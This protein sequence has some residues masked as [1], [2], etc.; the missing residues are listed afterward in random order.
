MALSGSFNT[1]GSYSTTDGSP[2]YTVFSWSGTQNIE[3][4][5][6]DVAWS[7]TV[8]GGKNEYYFVYV[9]NRLVQ[10]D[11]AQ[12]GKGSASKKS[13]NGTVLLSGTTRIYHNDDGTG[14]FT[15]YAGV[16][17]YYSGVYNSTKTQTFT[18]DTIPR[19]PDIPTVSSPTTTT[20]SETSTSI[21]VK[22]ATTNRGTYTVEVSKNGGAYSAVKTDIAIGTLSYVHTITPKQGDTYRYRIKAVWNSLSSDY[23]YSGTVTLNK[24]N[25]PTIGTLNTYN[26]YVNATLSVPLS[27]GSQTNGGSFM[28]MAALYHGSTKLATCTTPSNGN[29]TASISYSTTNFLSRLGTT[30]Y[31]D[32][33]KIVAWIQN[34][35]GSVSSSVEKTFTVNINSDGGATPTLAIPTLSGGMLGYPATCFVAGISK[36]TVTSGTAAT[37]RAPSGTT[38]SYTIAC[39]GA[40]TATS[41]STTFNGLTA[42]KKTITVTVKDSRGLSTSQTVYCKFQSW[43]KPTIK[44]TKAERNSTTPTTIN[45]TYEYSITNIYAYSTNADTAGTQLNAINTQQYTTA[46]SYTACTSPFS[47]TGTSEESTYT[48]TVRVSDKVATTTYSSAARTVGTSTVYLASRSHGIGLNCIPASGY[49]LDVNGKARIGSASGGNAIIDNGRITSNATTPSYLEGSKGLAL[50]NSTAP[51]GD[52]IALTKTNST[53]GYFTLA[54]YNDH[55]RLNYMAKSKIDANDNTNTHSVIL[56]KEDGTSGFA[57]ANHTHS[58]YAATNHGNHVP[59]TQTAS[60]KVFLRNDNT[61]QTIT[62]ANI[63]AAAASHTHGNIQK[64]ASARG[65]A[66]SLSLT[67]GTITQ[68]TLS[69]FVARTDTS[70]SFSDGGVKCP[71]AG[72]VMVSG[73]VYF[74][75]TSGGRGVY[76]KKGD[77]EIV[78]TYAHGVSAVGCSTSGVAIISVAAGDIIYLCARSTVAT[79]CR[80]NNNGTYL[81]I[82]Y[83]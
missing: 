77:D 72:T 3:G 39:T 4:N 35:N 74:D 18:L 81:N 55:F 16:G 49:R 41:S 59:A 64:A 6:T 70:F 22:W 2:D 42:G 51:A 33:F 82:A 13:F 60:N 75:S 25:A 62:P 83:I 71:Y 37:R 5:Y 56:L 54:S 78:S 19:H 32:T 50:V 80:P 30:K 76:I 9:Y 1:S 48:I 58:N 43:A 7:L 38:L 17:F 66:A 79:T 20:V 44:I 8:A 11:G 46:S 10:I 12:V 28:R 23:S 24:L 34:S 53:N 45:V 40:T 65:T 67:A 14:S 29:T 21:T 31:S 69:S 73:N 27:G 36:L 26:P 57:F 68:L 15:A 47:I 61:W 63:G 52:Y